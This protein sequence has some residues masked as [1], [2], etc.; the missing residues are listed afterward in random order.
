MKSILVVED[1]N[2]LRTILREGLFSEGYSVA[3]SGNGKQA[4]DHLQG[5][6]PDIVLTDLSM[7]EMDG[8]ELISHLNKDFADQ[9]CIIAMTGGL[10]SPKSKSSDYVLLR[11]ADALGATYTIEKPFRLNALLDLLKSIDTA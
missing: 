8:I 11:A 5:H 6:Q 10:P 9:F 3:E 7:P 4:L 1:D 2:D